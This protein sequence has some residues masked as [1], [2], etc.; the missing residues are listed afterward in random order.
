[1][2][3]AVPAGIACAPLAAHALTSKKGS[4]LA[5]D[6]Q[7]Y[8]GA[9]LR[10]SARF[11]ENA[12]DVGKAAGVFGRNL[13][14]VIGEDITFVPLTDL[15]GKSEDRIE[16]IVVDR[17]TKDV[18]DRAI[19]ANAASAS[20]DSG[21]GTLVSGGRRVLP[22]LW[23]LRRAGQPPRQLVLTSASWQ[24]KKSVFLKRRPKLL[25]KKS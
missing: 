8:D 23:L 5:S 17:V 1:M 18:L 9:S 19:A 20:D 4:V 2:I 15:S 3:A 10:E 22:G 25:P 11:L 16:E 7:L 6:G 24:K 14:V 12:K 21:A 13:F